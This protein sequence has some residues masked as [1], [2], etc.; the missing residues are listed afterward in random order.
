M[1]VYVL[2]FTTQPSKSFS[3][4]KIYTEFGLVYFLQG[5]SIQLLLATLV[6][7]SSGR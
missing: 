4:H 3:M 2:I 7:F 1:K 5:K 6:N